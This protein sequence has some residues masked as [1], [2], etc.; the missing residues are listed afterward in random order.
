MTCMRAIKLSKKLE[1]VILSEKRYKYL[2]FTYTMSL[3]YLVKY[4]I[5]ISVTKSI[6]LAISINHLNLSR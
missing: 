5:C 6:I 1:T 2:R 4:G 3:H